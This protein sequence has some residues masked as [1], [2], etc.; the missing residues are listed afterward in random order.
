MTSNLVIPNQYVWHVSLHCN[1]FHIC[2]NGIL[3]GRDQ[4][5]YANNH[6]VS[7]H[8]MWPLP[9]DSWD[10]MEATAEYFMSRYTFWRIDT[11]Q[12]SSE[13]EIDNNLEHDRPVHNLLGEHYYIRTKRLVPSSVILPFKY[14]Q[15]PDE[16][17]GINSLNGVANVESLSLGL[18]LVLDQ[19]LVDWREWR[20]LNEC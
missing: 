13:W 17:I 16:R 15:E 1:D 7:L 9:L 19:S 14:S 11:H 12:F 6:S 2:L 4:Y 8:Q 10:Y 3:P 5:V 18:P 20:A